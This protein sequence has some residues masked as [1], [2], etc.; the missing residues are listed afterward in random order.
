MEGDEGDLSSNYF[1]TPRMMAALSP[2]R[3]PRLPL[4]RDAIETAIRISTTASQLTAGIEAGRRGAL[5]AGITI[6][7]RIQAYPPD[8]ALR[9]VYAAL[10]YGIQVMI[11]EAKAAREIDDPLE[12]VARPQARVADQFDHIVFAAF[13]AALRQGHQVSQSD[14]G[15]F[16]AALRAG[17]SISH[18]SGTLAAT[19]GINGPIGTTQGNIFAGNRGG[20]DPSGDGAPATPGTP[21]PSADQSP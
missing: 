20:D 6:L 18:Y 10:P 7:G 1:T 9:D 2:T 17:Q 12:A 3:E 11:A 13:D 4:T 21:G 5:E 16:A 8:P 14:L 15:T 19:F